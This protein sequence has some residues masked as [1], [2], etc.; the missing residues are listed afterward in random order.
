MHNSSR[1]SVTPAT[2]R[3]SILVI[4]AIGV[5]SCDGGGGGNLAGEGEGCTKSADCEG[6]LRCIEQVCVSSGDADTDNDA[7]SGAPDEDLSDLM[8][9]SEI[10][11]EVAIEL[12]PADWDFIR[13]QTRTLSMDLDCPDGPVGSPFVYRSGT[14]TVNGERYE[15]V[16]VRKKGF[17]GSLDDHKPSLKIKFDEFVEGQEHSSLDRLTLNNNKSD[18]EHVRQCIAYQLF[19]A[20]GVPAPRCNFAHVTVNGANLG[21]FTHLDSIKKRFLSQH[22]EDNDGNLY[23][24]T[25]SDF[26]EGRTASLEAKT[27][28]D[29]PD[30]SDIAALVAALELPDNDLVAALESL[31]DIDEFLDFWAIEMLTNHIDGYA[32]GR[33][34]F[35]VYFDPT[36]GLAHFIPWGADATFTHMSKHGSQLVYANATLA[37]RLYMLPSTRARFLAALEEILDTI[38]DEEALITEIDRMEALIAPFVEDDPFNTGKNTPEEYIRDFIL[39]KRDE[40]QAVL[41]NPPVWTGTDENSCEENPG[42]GGGRVRYPRFTY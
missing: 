33:N 40:I 6:D 11:V 16:G 2:I 18:A 4:S 19:T 5:A 37:R 25:I 41:D 38:W 15:N 27:N 34:N 39:G 35:Y 21:L 8:F 32:N 1:G 30:R 22:F 20:A 42:D 13:T 14:V 31:I 17:L 29:T 9:D 24:G 26:R 10:I 12:H 36:T 23:E 3:L 7:D 28:K